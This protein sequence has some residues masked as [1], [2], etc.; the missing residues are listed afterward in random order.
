VVLGEIEAAPSASVAQLDRSRL[1]FPVTALDVALMGAYRRTPWFRR[2]VAA[3]G[4]AAGAALD[5]VGMLDHAGE[6]FGTLSGGQRQRVLIAR[7][8]VQD[9][10]LMLLDEPFSGVDA[11]SAA[12]IEKVLSE[13]R[14]EGRTI[15]VAT[16]DV[17]QARRFD[18]VLCIH[19]RQ[20]AYG[21]PKETLTPE[22]LQSTYGAELIMLGPGSAVAVDHH[23]H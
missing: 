18:R 14:D 7:A 13:L 3:D 5:R 2:I 20:I 21:A 11:A 1:D 19:Q 6:L 16:H 10:P 17:N 4:D 9:A 8:L 15:V 12:R 23:A 22:V